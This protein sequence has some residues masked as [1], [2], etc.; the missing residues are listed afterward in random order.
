MVIPSSD[1]QL[2]A[3]T[4]TCCVFTYFLV[5]RECYINEIIPC[6]T[7]GAISVN[8]ISQD[9]CFHPL[10]SVFLTAKVYNFEKVQLIFLIDLTF[11]YMF[12][13]C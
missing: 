4:N 13:S 12:N 3:A 6:V 5:F 10:N 9:F 1:L 2:M 7:F 8:V 11:G